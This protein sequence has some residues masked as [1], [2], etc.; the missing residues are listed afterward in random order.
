MDGKTDDRNHRGGINLNSSGIVSFVNN[1]V[2]Y[3]IK[4]IR[5]AATLLVALTVS[6]TAYPQSFSPELNGTMMPFDFSRCDSTVPWG[7]DLKPVFI[8]YMSRH[9]AR[10][11]SSEK[12]VESLQRELDKA[13]SEGYLSEKGKEFREVLNQVDSATDGNWG[14][15][16]SV[17]MEEE[18]RLGK[19]MTAIAPELLKKGKIGAVATYVP[20]VVMTMYELCHEL[21]KYSSGLEINTSEGRQ[22]NEMLRFFTTDTA[23]VDYLEKGRW[24]NA[25]DSFVESNVS[26]NPAQ[27]LFSKKMDAEKMRKLTLDMYG[28]L[29]SLPAA[30]LEWQPEKWFSE[31]EYR[32]CWE[33]G[34]LK[35][36][37][38]RSVS[39]FSDLPAS[40]A[41]PL[42]KDII[43]STDD[44]FA[45]KGD[46]G[47]I[48]R[49]R[50]GHAETV[51][52]LFALM[53]LPGCYVPEGN[54]N[55]ISE[56]WKDWEVSPLGANLLIVALTDGE[57]NE[58][59]ALRL[60]G[61]WINLRYE[62][63][64]GYASAKVIP[65]KDIKNEWLS[66]CD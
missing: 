1:S 35:H 57:G 34:N 42:L 17:G 40:C 29:Q 8:N 18:Q 52:P 23:Y 45:G 61:E 62:T 13:A 59:V 50:F 41:S 31:P 58:F 27:S 24:T 21:A 10:F 5:N 26:P 28:V 39:I 4:F 7:N 66:Y 33:A 49:L 19:E 37:Y 3:M 51:I 14:A 53:R 48:G 60:N 32:I 9:G 64:T 56:H 6:L 43:S 44:A 55:E 63:S 12:K 22:Y 25:Y 36:Y 11:L 46:T 65:W 2:I 15:L 47:I 20:R 38:Q 30:R 16:N 54:A